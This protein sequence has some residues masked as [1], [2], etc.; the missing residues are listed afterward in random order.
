MKYGAWPHVYAL[1]MALDAS[2]WRWELVE[3]EPEQTP[4]R[5]LVRDDGKGGTVL[6]GVFAV[7]ET[8]TMEARAI[9][10]VSPK[11]L[12]LLGERA[13]LTED[14]KERLQWLERL[15][16]RLT[17]RSYKARRS[18]E[19]RDLQELRA[20]LAVLLQLADATSAPAVDELLRWELEAKEQALRTGPSNA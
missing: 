18:D 12:R 13:V 3:T 5:A 16:Q 2:D 8:L 15:A 11:L 9:A 7:G 6:C 20:T 4:M 17:S 1:L 10:Q 14:I 19:Y